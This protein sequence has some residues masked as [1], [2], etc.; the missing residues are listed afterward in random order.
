MPFPLRIFRLCMRSF[1][2]RAAQ[3]F[4]NQERIALGEKKGR[5]L[6]HS[7]LRSTARLD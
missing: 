1:G 3:S 4:V 7:L 5:T 2:H 6:W